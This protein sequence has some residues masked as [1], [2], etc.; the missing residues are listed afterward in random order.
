VV[1]LKKALYGCIESARLWYLD[2][3]DFLLSVGFTISD[4]DEC[5]F[6]RV[7]DEETS[8]IIVFV[9]DFM[10]SCNTNALMDKIIES[11]NTKYKNFTVRRGTTHS[12]LGMCFDFNDGKVK[13]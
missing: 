8:Y 1:K 6:K 13:E 11:I 2:V 4:H 3:K 12:Y 5:L 9:D 10:I 7:T